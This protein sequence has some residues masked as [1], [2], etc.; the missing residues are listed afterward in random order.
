[1]LARQSEKGS[2]ATEFIIIAPLLTLLLYV[3][4]YLNSTVEKRQFATISSRNLA[5]ISPESQ[6]D[7]LN[8]ALLDVKNFSVFGP[9]STNAAP[10]NSSSS[11]LNF[12]SHSTNISSYYGSSRPE[13]VGRVKAYNS[14]ADSSSFEN[15]SKIEGHIAGHGVDI[16]RNL[17]NTKILS[18]Y[19]LI[20]DR[21]SVAKIELD[22][23]LGG[24]LFGKSIEGLT[25][26]IDSDAIG[27]PLQTSN[28]YHRAD[29]GFHPSSYQYQ[30]LIG[31]LVGTSG[32]KEHWSK[33]YQR[34]NTLTLHINIFG[35][36][37]MGKGFVS[38]CMMHFAVNSNCDYRPS[39]WLALSIK[40]GATV[41]GVLSS[42]LSLGSSSA[43]TVAAKKAL[44]TALTELQNEIAEKIKDEATHSVDHYIQ[45]QFD[46]NFKKV[47]E[48]FINQ[49]STQLSGIYNPLKSQMNFQTQ[50]P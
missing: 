8:S 41:M 7:L 4:Y 33:P 27:N 25:S 29:V 17:K 23:P 10:F 39:N 21:L 42:V 48:K 43:Y 13:D 49:V 28:A 45:D 3:G 6:V 11:S 15:L 40:A 1:M 22:S 26:L 35:L 44:N 50:G 24:N 14:R 31:W 16:L 30:A 18:Q 19:L 5:V 12:G 2:I 20:P 37:N 36:R 38:E 32:G 9:D 47:R 34:S 46:S